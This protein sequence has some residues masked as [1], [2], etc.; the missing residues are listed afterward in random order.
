MPRPHLIPDP[1]YRRLTAPLRRRPAF[2]ILGA[3]KAGTS[4]LYDL[5]GRHPQVIPATVKEVHFFDLHFGRG[6][7]WYRSHFPL[8]WRGGPA[9]ITGEASPYYLFHPHCARRIAALLPE[10]KLIVLLRDPVA[11]A[12]SHFQHKRRDGGETLSFEEAIA[13]EPE[14]LHGEHE[15]LLA[16]E[17][18]HSHAHQHFSYLA[19]GQY[20]EQLQAY[21]QF[22]RREQMLVLSSEEFFAR[23]CEVYARVLRFLGLGAWQPSQIPVLNRG[24]Y[25]R[26]AIPGAE[27]LRDYFAPHNR[28]LYEYLG[29]DFGW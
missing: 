29:V 8:L 13:R 5:L 23:P 7:G 22:F 12:Y 14:R 3:Q 6:V 27:R 28:R 4:T 18:Y 25:D 21:H 19:R 20:L 1:T 10:V 9:A 15:R 2:L 26:D 16:D 17:T 11:R 24:D